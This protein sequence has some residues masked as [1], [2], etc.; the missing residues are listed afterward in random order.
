M[1]RKSK[2]PNPPCINCGKTVPK[3]TVSV[4]TLTKDR[5]T[6][7]SRDPASRWGDYIQEEGG[8]PVLKVCRGPRRSIYSK[9]ERWLW[10][11]WLGEW[12]RDGLF[13]CGTCAQEWGLKKAR[14]LYGTRSVV[15]DSAG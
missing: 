7:V 11:V 13:H 1:S 14:D 4:K 12:E 3:R 8:V 2:H 9:E 5:P 15:Q 6:H 10:S